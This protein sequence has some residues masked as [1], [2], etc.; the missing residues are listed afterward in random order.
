MV[1]YHIPEPL[2][3]VHGVLG[4]DMRKIGMW[5]RDGRSGDGM[6]VSHDAIIRATINV[7]LTGNTPM[8]N[9]SL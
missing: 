8:M 4:G 5:Y 6:M 2:H 3:L 7:G 9:A 1:P